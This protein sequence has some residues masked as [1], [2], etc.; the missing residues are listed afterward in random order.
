MTTLSET[1]VWRTHHWDTSV[2]VLLLCS[3]QSIWLRQTIHSKTR[4]N[5][6]LSS[7]WCE[8]WYQCT[9]SHPFSDSDPRLLGLIADAI[10]TKAAHHTPESANQICFPPSCSVLPSHTLHIDCIDACAHCGILRICMHSAHVPNSSYLDLWVMSVVRFALNS[11]FWTVLWY[12]V[13]GALWKRRSHKSM[14]V[15]KYE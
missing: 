7:S 9:P 3:K 5:Q 12:N 4:F 8:M 6:H 1:K 10:V 15:I 13:T 14:T 11:R 2:I